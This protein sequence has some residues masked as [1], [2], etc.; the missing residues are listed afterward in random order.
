VVTCWALGAEDAV[1]AELSIVARYQ[2]TRVAVALVSGVALALIAALCVGTGRNVTARLAKTLVNVDAVALIGIERVSCGALPTRTVLQ[3]GAFFAHPV[4]AELYK[5]AC[6]AKRDL[7]DGA[8]LRLVHSST[9]EITS[10]AH[11]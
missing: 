1:C 6:F 4:F 11:T 3:I 5:A 10:V 7:C 2:G 8:K 9:A